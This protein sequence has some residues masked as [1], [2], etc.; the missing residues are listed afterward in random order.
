MT[1]VTV[2]DSLVIRGTVTDVSP[3]TQ[4]DALKLRFPNGVPAVSDANMS[5]WMGYVYEQFPTPT[6]V[7]GVQVTIDVIDANGNYR[8]IGTTTSDSSGMFT[9]AWTPDITGSYTVIATF[10]GSQS[11]YGSS[12]E[13]SFVASA[14]APT[15]SPY[16]VAANPLP[17]T[18][19]YI[20][21]AAAAII[22]AIAIVGALILMAVKKRP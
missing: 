13:S 10:A 15:A 2:G 12:A 18:E 14:A 7:N 9:F 21:V 4:Q 1:G 8:N 22:V 16:P 6:N 19:M 5:D 17:S 11:Y 3:G 20:A